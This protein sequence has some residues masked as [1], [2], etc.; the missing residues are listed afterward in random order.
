MEMNVQKGDRVKAGQVIARLDGTEAKESF[1]SA[2]NVLGSTQSVY[3]NTSTLFDAQIAATKEKVAQSLQ[4]ISLAQAS[5]D[6]SAT[7]L[8]DTKN[9][10]QDSLLTAQKQ[11]EQSTLAE[12]TTQTQYENTK[13]LLDQKEQYIY[14][15][16]LNTLH[17]A[18]V[19]AMSLLDFTDTLYGASD[20]N[21]HANDAF[22]TYF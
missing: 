9:T 17:S 10:V 18:D 11:V 19:L 2:N 8:Q 16:A 1:S 15:N 20:A 7:G 3:G 13:N 4:N 14:L 5:L 6:G 12:E 22:E 21:R